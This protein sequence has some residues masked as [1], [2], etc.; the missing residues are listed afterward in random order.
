MLNK[1]KTEIEKMH[2]LMNEHSHYGATDTEP[3]WQWQNCLRLAVNGNFDFQKVVPQHA[4]GWELFSSMPGVHAVAD[5][6]SNQATEVVDLIRQC[7]MEELAELRVHLEVEGFCW[8]V[9]L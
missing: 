5:E 7:S 3:D 1:I 2:E 8:R 4:E 9:D 6:L